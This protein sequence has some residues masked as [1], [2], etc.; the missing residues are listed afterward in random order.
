MGKNAYAIFS[1]YNLFD[2]NLDDNIKILNIAKLDSD[3]IIIY[4]EPQTIN[5]TDDKDIYDL[6]FKIIS[7]NQKKL[8]FF[9]FFGGPMNCKRKN[10]ELLCQIKKNTLISCSGDEFL[11]NQGND[12]K[13]LMYFNKEGKAEYLNSTFY[14]DFYVQK[15]NVYVNIT[16]LLTE[17]VGYNDIFVYETNITDIPSLISEDFNLHFIGEMENE[18]FLYCYFKKGDYD[19][20]LLFC[21]SHYDDILYLKESN[22]SIILDN[23]NAKY[24]FIIASIKNNENVTVFYKFNNISYPIIVYINPEVLNFNLKDTFEID[25][26]IAKPAEIFGITFNEEEKDLKCENL[27]NIKR[28]L[29]TE[30]N[31]RG[32]NDS[33][34][35]IKYDDLNFNNKKIIFY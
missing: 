8:Y 19:P 15:V 31:F 1:T 25:I 24:N 5:V 28:C 17:N 33:Y 18:L 3:T 22:D 27:I 14:V 16:K 32:K 30:E 7:Y 29:V 13:L 12:N 9:S 11:K 20:L 34:Y 35:Y 10:E 6:K 26:I 23:I 4:S 21:R 2:I